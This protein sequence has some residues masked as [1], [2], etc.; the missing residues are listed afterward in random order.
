MGPLHANGLPFHKFGVHLHVPRLVRPIPVSLV[1][2]LFDDQFSSE[3]Q[4][5]HLQNLLASNC[6]NELVHLYHEH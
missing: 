1:G 2:T 5:Y 6:V 4:S 3:V